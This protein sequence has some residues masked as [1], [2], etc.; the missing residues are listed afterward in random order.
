MSNW[1][2]KDLLRIPVTPSKRE[3]IRWP[4]FLKPILWL[5]FL[6]KIGYQGEFWKPHNLSFLKMSLIH[7]LIA[8]LFEKIELAVRKSAFKG[9]FLTLCT[10]FSSIYALNLIPEV[11]LRKLRLWGFQNSPWYPIL[12]K[13]CSHSM[14][15]KKFGHLLSSPLEGVTGILSKSSMSHFD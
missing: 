3:P 12:S 1:H 14:G 6:L 7:L 15:L 5:H 4:N 9:D 11:I 10:F 13:N 8:K 2:T